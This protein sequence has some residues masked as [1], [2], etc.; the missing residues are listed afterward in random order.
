MRGTHTLFKKYAGGHAEKRRPRSQHPSFDHTS[1]NGYHA[2]RGAGAVAVDLTRQEMERELKEGNWAAALDK[3][4]FHLGHLSPG[5][6]FDP[7]MA[8]FEDRLEIR[9]GGR[10]IQIIRVGHC[11]AR[12]DSVVWMPEEKILFAG[13]L[14]AN[15]SHTATGAQ[16][17]R[18]RTSPTSKT[19]A[20]ARP[21][22]SKKK[23][24]QKRPP[25]K[26][27]CPSA[28]A[29]PSPTTSPLTPLIWPGI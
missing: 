17:S 12:G 14:I 6:A 21:P 27:K 9:Y 25:P 26:C 20:D 22:P 10:L 19:Y 29:G 11:H 16:K 23:A 24:H 8:T 3:S 28:G 5:L 18:M 13:D 7:P 1:D 2:R 4:E 15:C